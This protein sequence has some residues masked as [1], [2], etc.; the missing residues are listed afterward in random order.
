MKFLSALVPPE[1]EGGFTLFELVIVIV[2]IG[3]LA[4][5]AVP[6]YLNLQREARI[7]VL[8]TV[9]NTLRSGSLL[10]FA[11]AASAGLQ[12]QQ[13]Q[14]VRIEDGPP[15]VQV[16]ADFGY[17]QARRQDI[18]PLFDNPSPRLVWLGGSATPGDS[19]VLRMDGQA[20]C[21]VRYTAPVGASSR[22]QISLTTTQC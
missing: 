6:R 20:D 19:L 13:D 21:E 12:S 1:S 14:V 9:E 3:V 2:I 10:V 8:H 16:V 7:A 15:L 4:A 18:E 5:I 11:R 22:P 17:P